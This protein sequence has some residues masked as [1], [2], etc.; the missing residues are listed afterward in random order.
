ML[1][2]CVVIETTQNRTYVGVMSYPA[3]NKQHKLLLDVYSR[4]K[5]SMQVCNFFSFAIERSDCVPLKTFNFL[6]N[7]S[8]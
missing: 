6:A 3:L 5:T 1:L 2:F 7:Y 4:N 8:L